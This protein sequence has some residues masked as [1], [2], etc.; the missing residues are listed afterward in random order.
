LVTPIDSGRAAVKL[1]SGFHS[2]L[3]AVAVAEE[4]LIIDPIVLMSYYPYL[5]KNMKSI[6]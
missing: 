6:I 2:W 5:E 1:C 3:E 4:V